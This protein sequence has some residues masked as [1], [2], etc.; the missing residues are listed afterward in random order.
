MGP[1]R[2]LGSNASSGTNA[3]FKTF[4]VCKDSWSSKYAAGAYDGLAVLMYDA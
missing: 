4:I 1:A 3:D 2:M